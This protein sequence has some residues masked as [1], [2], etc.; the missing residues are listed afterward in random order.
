[1][2]QS[3]INKKPRIH[4]SKIILLL[5]LFASLAAWILS[6]PFWHVKEILISGNAIVEKQ[7][8]LDKAKIPLKENIFFMNY[9]E[10]SRRIKEIPQIKNAFVSGRIP[11][12]LE[13]K[14]KERKP[15]CVF[16]IDQ[17]YLIA[18]DEGYIINLDIDHKPIN[19]PHAS[20]LP[21]VLG[22]PK[23]S[24]IDGKKIS[25]QVI[26]AAKKSFNILSA[27]LKN[28]RFEIEMKNPD[29]I[30]IIIDD[31]FKIKIGNLEN[32]DQKLKVISTLLKNSLTKKHNIEYFDVRVIDS[33]AVRFR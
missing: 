1:M 15:F 9:K 21:V 25:L 31:I 10:I 5:I 6:L 22:L 32:I 19:I 12:N 2:K 16:I 29:N 27:L 24:I 4:F 28:S 26:E 13:I 17:K 11:N 18:D 8:I 30:S 7:Q 20:N 3:P 23:E 14:I 33:P